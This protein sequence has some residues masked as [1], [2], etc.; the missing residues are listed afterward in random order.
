VAFFGSGV[1]RSPNNGASFCFLSATELTNIRERY[2]VPFQD[3]LPRT[4]V[5]RTEAVIYM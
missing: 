5:R 3:F 1:S 2:N 4:V